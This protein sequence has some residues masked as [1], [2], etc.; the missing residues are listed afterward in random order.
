VVSDIAAPPA[1]LRN[2]PD[3]TLRDTAHGPVLV[4]EVPRDPYTQPQIEVTLP[5]PT[6]AAWVL[7]IEHVDVGAGVIAAS[8]RAGDSAAWQGAA[9]QANFTR[10][11]TGAA[12]RAWFAFQAA[13]DRVRIGG[14]PW[15]RALRILP[16]QEAAAWQAR[17]DAVPADVA[18]MVSLARPISLT[19]TA[20][21]D[22]AG[23]MDT[24][25]ASLA[26]MREYVP[27]AKVLGFT[28]IESYVTWKRLEPAA[29]GVFDFSFYDAITAEL[30][31][32]GMKWLPLLIVG[33]AYALPDWFLGGPED[34][35]MVCLEHGASNPVQSIAAPSQ[36][37]HVTRVLRAFGAH[38]EPTGILEAVRLGPSGNYGESQYP[39]G[40]NWGVKGQPMHI[41]IGWWAGDPH[42]VSDY[43]RFLR[44]RYGDV[45]AL[46]TAWQ[47]AVTRFEDVPMPLPSHMN[48]LRQ[49]L[50]FTEWYTDLMSDWCAWWAHEARAALPNTPMYQSA[51]GWGF[52][53]AGT[54]YSA[55]TQAMAAVAGGI[56]LTNETDSYEQ[57]FYATRLAATAARHYGVPLGYEPA[58]GHTAR[59]VA[60]RLYHAIATDAAH[61]FTYQG[62]VMN[63]PYA[64]QQWLDHLPL[65]D[66][67]QA[68][69]VE[70]A[71]YYPET[72]NQI[73]DGAFRHLY[74][75]GF[76]PRAAALRRVV[77]VDYLDERL[78]RDGFLDQYNVLV[79]AWGNYIEPDVQR[80]IDAWLRAGGT[81]FYP[82]FPRGA[83][84]TVDGDTAVFNRWAGGDTGAGRFL[85]Y[86]GDM[87]P[88]SGYARFVGRH[89]REMPELHPHT[90]LAL[91]AERPEEVFLTVQAD[92]HL[93]ALNYTDDPAA[94]RV[95]G[96]DPVEIPAHGIA[97]MPLEGA[98]P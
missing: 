47:A 68:A 62:N 24:L 23:G 60:G 93:L 1:W 39:A 19:T 38:Y 22:V 87:E 59:G 55:Q 52:R 61:W 44:E 96:L 18:P 92:G 3:C 20:G 37:R 7:E 10:L 5:A 82:S 76:N 66:T 43:H 13:A 95:P 27:L 17:R 57:N 15:I 51:G 33:S 46:N 89:L 6:G 85:R 21:I 63:H 74:A 69:R 67:R 98:A 11:N 77:D 34:H 84:Q 50:D 80:H 58:S 32:H 79:F 70:V 53:E 71:V 72:M 49:R 86:P 83:Q 42:A 88:P 8:A 41:H 16:P 81:V 36:R 65:L 29:E 54:D 56:R 90:R 78:I 25:D 28:S 75:W 94:L 30:T 35:G 40:G 26:A 9:D 31:R 4:R 64:I 73:D 97:R 45:A 91:A 48:V 2:T 12:R 14:A